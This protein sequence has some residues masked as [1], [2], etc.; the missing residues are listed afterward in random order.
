MLKSPLIWYYDIT[1]RDNETDVQKTYKMLEGP[2]SFA[3]E[4]AKKKYGKPCTFVEAKH[5]PLEYDM[6]VL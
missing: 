3:I 4:D 6:E 1:V 2:I 5:I